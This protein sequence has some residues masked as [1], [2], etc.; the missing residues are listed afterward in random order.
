M[1]DGVGFVIL[2]FVLAYIGFFGW[3]GYVEAQRPPAPLRDAGN[4]VMEPVCPY[5]N[6][7]LVTATRKGG[8]GLTG[9]L[10]RLLALIGVVAL[11]FNWLAGGILLILAVLLGMAGKSTETVLTCPACGRYEKPL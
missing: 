2:L 7:R 10:A 6:A 4:G 11:L 3:R 8:M 1:D 9:V 5:C